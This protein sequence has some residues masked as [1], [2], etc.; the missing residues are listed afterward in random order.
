MMPKEKIVEIILIPIA[1]RKR[2]TSQFFYMET[3]FKKLRRGYTRNWQVFIVDNFIRGMM[4]VDMKGRNIPFP[5]G[6]YCPW[7][8]SLTEAI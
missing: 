3:T 7:D 1:F 2:G 4:F 5:D 8:K 6:P